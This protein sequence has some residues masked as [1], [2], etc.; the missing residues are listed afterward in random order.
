MRA[1]LTIIAILLIL[2][3]LCAVILG[4]LSFFQSEAVER[5][6]ERIGVAVANGIAEL[7]WFG[8]F[9]GFILLAAIGAGFLAQ[10]TG[11]GLRDGA[12]PAASAVA[13][14]IV[15]SAIKAQIKQGIPVEMPQGW[16]L[17][18]PDRA[19]WLPE[20]ERPKITVGKGRYEDG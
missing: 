7:C 11:R 4:L 3:L 18:Q 6:T 9:G 5:T 2:G 16:R 20:P 8:A 19:R 1:A 13:M 12:Q 10:G 15:A 14:L 17:G